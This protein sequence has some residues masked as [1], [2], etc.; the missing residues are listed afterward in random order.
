MK[1][2]SKPTIQVLAQIKSKSR[3]KDKDLKQL[4]VHKTFDL[5]GAT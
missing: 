4:G 2:T 5:K 1:Y 3:K